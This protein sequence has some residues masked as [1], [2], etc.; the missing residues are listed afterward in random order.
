MP[1]F[2]GILQNLVTTNRR[3]Y[4]S[5][6][7]TG[8]RGPKGV[9]DGFPGGPR[10]DSEKFARF[11]SNITPRIDSLQSKASTSITLTL[12]AFLWNL[13]ITD[14]VGLFVKSSVP[15]N[16][17][18]KYAQWCPN[19][20]PKYFAVNFTVT[21]V[22][23]HQLCLRR[24]GVRSQKSL[25]TA[26]LRY[27]MVETRIRIFVQLLNLTLQQQAHDKRLR[28]TYQDK[29]FSS[30]F[31]LGSFQ[32]GVLTS[33]GLYERIWLVEP[34]GV[35]RSAQHGSW[36]HILK[37]FVRRFPKTFLRKTIQEF[38]RS[39]LIWILERFLCIS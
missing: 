17:M 7:Q 6:F 12:L 15:K 9:C 4:A 33:R 16:L 27:H 37:S 8:V 30:D 11:L 23:L 26:A 5:G 28:S 18:P 31:F 20:V 35:Q 1:S 19:L 3:L 38:Q 13:Y 22:G 25:R 32:T 39:F 29:K 14:D 2:E 24:I 10:E 36:G 34:A 21:S